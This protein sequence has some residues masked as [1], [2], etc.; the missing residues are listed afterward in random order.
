MAEQ[1]ESLGISVFCEDMAMMLEAGIMPEEAV[2][3]LAEDTK[4]NTTQEALKAMEKEMILGSSFAGAVK[5]SGAFPDYATDM[6]NTGERAGRLDQVLR[7]LSGY[8]ERQDNLN[9]QLRNAVIYPVVLLLMMCAV[10]VLMVTL[11]LPV[12]VKVY[13]NMTGA[14]AQSSYHYITIASVVS[15]VSLIVIGL[16]S[17]GVLF[18]FILYRTEKGSK[19]LVRFL[20]VFPLTKKAAR[21]L[22]VSRFIDVLATFLSSGMDVDTAFEDAS[23]LVT[24]P[25]LKAT[26]EK[27]NAEMIEGKSLAQAFYDHNVV[28]PL[29]GRM[30]LS[31]AR[32]G[33][34]EPQLAKLAAVTGI[35]AEEQIQGL[36]SALEPVLTGCL[37]LSVGVTLLSIML[38][39]AGMLSAIG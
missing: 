33:Q 37:T 22:E 19:L 31:A 32:S 9:R 7:S 20:Q 28:P 2:G 5:N 15:W 16:L 36:I 24:H 30:L 26:V 12:F 6:I 1:M 29:Y 11:V 4:E 18:C 13:E 8:Y 27:M 17:L 10:L 3:L 21:Q 38:P 25:E 34:I 39:L 23:S 35:D 14:L